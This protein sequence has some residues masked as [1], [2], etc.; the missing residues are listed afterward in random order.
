MNNLQGESAKP[1]NK[2][3]LVFLVVLACVLLLANLFLISKGLEAAN[4]EI[5]LME[6]ATWKNFTAACV[7]YCTSTCPRPVATNYSV[8]VNNFSTSGT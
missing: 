2:R 1:K 7:A 8:F 6:S 5:A 4:K 3:D